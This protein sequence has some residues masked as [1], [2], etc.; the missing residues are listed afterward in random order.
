MGNSKL[1]LLLYDVG[2]THAAAALAREAAL[3]FDRRFSSA[4]DSSGNAGHILDALEK[5]GRLVLDENDLALEDLSGVSLG[6]PGP[7]DYDLGISQMRHKFAGLYGVNLQSELALRFKVALDAVTF[8]NDACAY[9]LGEIHRGAASNVQRAIGITLGTGVGSAF[10]VDGRIVNAG[11]GVPNRGSLWDIP[12]DGGIIEDR[13]SARAIQDLHR[14]RTGECI[15]VQEISQRAR[16][17]GPALQ[18]MHQFGR[19]LGR[20]LAQTCSAFRPQV[21]V[22][23]GAISRSADLFLPAATAEISSGN[24]RL[25]MSELFDDA[26]L[27]GAG[28]RWLQV[29]AP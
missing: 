27:V 2:G 25:V 9:L 19:T 5:L 26:A 14:T 11:D 1:N 18:T 29:A 15:E 3:R 7:F 24:M 4:L 28:V 22:F 12:W 23:G 13:V 20:V 8:V 17:G 21:V 10:A 6:M 16:N